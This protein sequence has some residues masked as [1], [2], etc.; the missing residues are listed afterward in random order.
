MTNEEEIEC[1]SSLQGDLGT[2]SEEA[3]ERHEGG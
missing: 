2:H 1:V 3:G